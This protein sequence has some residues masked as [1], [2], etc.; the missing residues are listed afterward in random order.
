MIA[1]DATSENWNNNDNK[2]LIWN[3]YDFYPP[4][5]FHSL[6][7][8]W[9]QLRHQHSREI[10]WE[11]CTSRYQKSIL[12]LWPHPSSVE[13]KLKLLQAMTTLQQQQ[14][15]D[16][17]AMQQPLGSVAKLVA[18][19]IQEVPPMFRVKSKIQQGYCTTNACNDDDDDEESTIPVIDFAGFHLT[20]R[21]PLI[22]QQIRRASEDWG[23]FQVEFFCPWT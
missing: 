19:G 21:R 22:L 18:S 4:D 11:N 15:E 23:F 16:V 13:W 2:T 7:Y 5:M 8:I 10:Q 17:Q 14:Q 20:E 6:V 9:T 1:S 3:S 12:E